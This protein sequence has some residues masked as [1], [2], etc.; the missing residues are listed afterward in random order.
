[1]ALEWPKK[2]SLVLVKGELTAF[3]KSIKTSYFYRYSEARAK[4]AGFMK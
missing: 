4:R 3:G 2:V 1:M